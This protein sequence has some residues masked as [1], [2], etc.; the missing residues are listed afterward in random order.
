[1]TVGGRR[2]ALFTGRGY[3]R[4][5]GVGKAAAWVLV[6]QG[7]SQQVWLPARARVA[8]LRAFGAQIAD[9]VLIRHG[10]RIHWP[11]KLTVGADS[12]I[13]VGVWILN[14][15]PVHIGHDVCISQDAMLC[16]GSHRAEDPSFEYDNAAIWIDDEA[17]VA[18]RATILRGVRVG[19]GAVV[20]ATALVVRDIPPGTRVVAPAAVSADVS[21]RPA[22]P[23]RQE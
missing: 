19:A 10:V 20:G 22:D 3:N 5:A 12:W 4:G 7:L 15:E 9:G 21:A 6:G 17:W 11:W 16:T 23:T 1:M 13:G 14:L 8:L 18:V 2:L